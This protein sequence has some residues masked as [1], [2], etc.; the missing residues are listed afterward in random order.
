MNSNNDNKKKRQNGYY[1]QNILESFRDIG[2]SATNSLKKD[3]LSPLPNEV[4][5]QIFG[6]PK[7]TFSGEIMPGENLEMR[8]VVTGK[9]EVQEKEQR[10][11]YKISI[12]ESEEKALVEHR[13]GELKLELRAI[14]E[15]IISVVRVTNDLEQE[16]Q[17]AALQGPGD[18]SQYEMFF[19]E[20]ILNFIKSFR[21]KAEHAR[22][23]LMQQNKRAS[24]KNVWGQNYSKMKGKYLLSKEHY[25]SRSAG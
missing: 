22:T 20:H 2:S 11:T 3:L 12:L 14:H 9:R 16:V 23:W 18:P 24:K 4:R 19:L 8:D 10:Q 1:S 21:E 5:N 17:I 7:R 25:L 13:M 15:E 6:L